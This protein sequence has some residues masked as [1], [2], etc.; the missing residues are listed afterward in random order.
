MKFAGRI[1]KYY[2]RVIAECIPL[3]V[4]AGLL[5]VLSS[6]IFQNRYVSE[7]SNILSFLVIPVFMGYK[8]GTMC[9]GDAG[10]LAGTLA[11]SAVVMTEPA[12][13]MILSAI[14]GSAAGYL[15]RK[16]LDRIKHRIPAGFE[17]LFINLYLSGLGLLAGALTHYLLI[18]VAAW[19]LTFLGNGLSLMIARG[20]IPF[21]SIVVEPLK[22]IFF[23]NWINHGFFLPLGLEQMKT[24]GSSILFL[25]ETNPGPGFGILLAYTLVH[26]N[27]KKQMLSS[28]I[29]Q[30][31]GG[32]HEVYF[33][34][35]LSDIRLLA[36]AIA[37][38]IAGNYCFMATGS[39]L[40]GPASPGSVI[41][42][43]IMADKQHW[44]G[45]LM[46]IFVSAGVTCLLS[47]LIMS[48]EK[49]KPVTDE[50]TIQKDKGMQMKKI[51]HARIYFVCDVGMG[52]SAMASALFKKRLKLE[53]ITDAQ[54]FHV[55]ADRIP[56][57]ADVIVCQKDF[58][59]SLSGIDKPCFTVD[60]LTD[61]SGYKELLNW[62]R[63]GGEDGR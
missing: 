36:A 62:L 29:I 34:Y 53:G 1:L 23:N 11:A 40:L 22:I 17:M 18:P 31:L 51:E 47:C 60:N 27:T 3:F 45:I 63:G 48:G 9:G 5:S 39:G 30:S 20:I 32:I 28:L 7:M 49:Q 14:A 38:S 16:G 56:P 58:A 25:L 54:V 43:M 19:L 15:C 52:S 57:D 21:I 35:I 37:G 50:E 41:T 61:M 42:I 46:G 33:P 8:A 59:R 24:Q 6:V 12:S 44:L 13:A 55:S 2:S 26:R 4:T 10:G